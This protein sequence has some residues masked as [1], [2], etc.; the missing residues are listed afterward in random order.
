[1]ENNTT[2]NEVIQ[3]TTSKAKNE[4][5]GYKAKYGKVYQVGITVQPDDFTTL[6]F[7]Y[8]FK[9]PNTASF[10]RYVKSASQSS[11]KALKMFIL[12]NIIEEQSAKL[13]KDLEEYPALALSVGEKLLNML[14]L[15][16]D[17]NLKLL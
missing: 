15:S 4:V 11:T 7:E 3:G 1:M 9:K 5:E 16:K 17:I 10:D 13:E 8:I 6:E 12:D 14:G 2:A